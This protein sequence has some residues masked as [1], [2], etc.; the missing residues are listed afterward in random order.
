MASEQAR[1]VIAASS[2]AACETMFA[3]VDKTFASMTENWM[4]RLCSDFFQ[5][6]GTLLSPQPVHSLGCGFSG[7]GNEGSPIFQ[8]CQELATSFAAPVSTNPVSART[9]P[10]SQQ[11]GFHIPIVCQEEWL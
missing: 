5:T 9:I 10:S 4:T 3:C 1:S 11:T 6:S 7:D 8:R 2:L